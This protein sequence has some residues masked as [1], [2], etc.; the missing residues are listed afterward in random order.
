MSVNSTDPGVLFGGTWERIQ[1]AFLLGAG[2][3]AAGSTGG[4]ETVTL[5]VDQIP[6]HSHGIDGALRWPATGAGESYDG[7]A[8][9]ET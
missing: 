9:R 2:S 6:T 7:G 4:S 8:N 1:D 5:T 3:H